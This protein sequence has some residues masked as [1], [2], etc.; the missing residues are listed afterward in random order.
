MEP[1]GTKPVFSH[2][3]ATGKF[4]RDGRIGRIF[5][6]GTQSFREISATDSVHVAV[7]PDNHVS[8]HVDSVSPLVASEG[9]CRYSIVRAV[10]HNVS[11][12]YEVICRVVRREHRSNS[13]HME[14][15]VVWVPDDDETAADDVEAVSVEAVSVE[16]VGVEADVRP[17]DVAA[18][19]RPSVA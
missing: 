14:C 10:A 6:P 7:T 16:A 1:Q 9:R 2:L 15:E 19:V 18:D 11:V 3:D 17:S 5:H 8:V 13:C 4:F 12:A